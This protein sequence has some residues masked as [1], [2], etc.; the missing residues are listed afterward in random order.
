LVDEATKRGITTLVITDIN[1]S[2]A[3]LEVLKAAVGKPLK[4]IAGI[5]FQDAQNRTLYIGI[6]Q[7]RAGFQH[8][9]GNKWPQWLHLIPYTPE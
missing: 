9:L 6:A 4:L 3:F 2:T 7:N 1:N 8:L 5:E